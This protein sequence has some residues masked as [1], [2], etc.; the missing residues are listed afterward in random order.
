MAQRPGQPSDQGG[1]LRDQSSIVNTGRTRIISAYIAKGGVGKTTFCQTVATVLA[2]LGRKVAL[3]DTDKQA[4]ASS[5]LIDLTPIPPSRRFS[6]ANVV[7]DHVPLL[8]ALYQAKPNLW[9]VAA[10]DRV[11]D[12]SI[13]IDQLAAEYQAGK[14]PGEHPSPSHNIMADRLSELQAAI[15]PP[16]LRQSPNQLP[17]LLQISDLKPFGR[18][19]PERLLQ[20]PDY[21]DFII[22]DHAPNPMALG[23]ACLAI[24]TEIWAPVIPEPQPFEGLLQMLATVKKLFE[25][26]QGSPAV[27]GIL[28]SQVYHRYQ[29]HNSTLAA[30]YAY[31]GDLITRSIHRAAEIPN[32]QGEQPPQTVFEYARSSRPSKEWVEIALRI[33]EYGGTLANNPECEYCEQIRMG[34]AAKVAEASKGARH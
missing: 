33:D 27:R 9:V 25:G 7:L 29:V 26:V 34:I 30:L 28:P 5:N 6:I 16:P 1:K 32:A 8:E 24:S 20:K 17:L 18:V 11:N 21:L 3:I 4:N 13:Y 2:A 22:I 23:N 15:A 14:A 19:P 12:A 10:D 31:F